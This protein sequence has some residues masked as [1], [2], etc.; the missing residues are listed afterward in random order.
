MFGYD[1]QQHYG[2]ASLDGPADGYAGVCIQIVF[3][4]IGDREKL[5]HHQRR[6]L[7]EAQLL[8][9]VSNFRVLSDFCGDDAG[10][11]LGA[12]QRTRVKTIEMILGCAQILAGHR[13]LSL[14][15]RGQG[16]MNVVAVDADRVAVPDQDKFRRQLWSL[17]MC[18]FI[19][20]PGI[21]LN[22]NGSRSNRSPTLASGVLC[23]GGRR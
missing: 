10:R 18:R 23:P 15:D 11:F 9:A 21:A 12:A 2:N 13:S 1:V 7:P 17:R 3:D 14:P 6:Q 16:R 22:A 4:R 20:L 8:H 19:K 5:E